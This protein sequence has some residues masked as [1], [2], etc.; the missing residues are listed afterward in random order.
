[1]L[2]VINNK[3]YYDGRKDPVERLVIAFDFDA[4]THECILIK[5]G[6]YKIIQNRYKNFEN[7]FKL[8]NKKLGIIFIDIQH[9]FENKHDAI[10]LIQFILNHTS[11]DLVYNFVEAN[12][13]LD[14][15]KVTQLKNEI[16][17][18]EKIEEG[19]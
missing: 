16:V 2:K 7:M 17:E 5:V 10:D 6:D 8:S 12:I 18:K 3:F 4:Y 14:F 9:L 15:D 11:N 19:V 1:M 13:N